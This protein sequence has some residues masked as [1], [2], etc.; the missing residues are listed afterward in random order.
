MSASATTRARSDRRPACVAVPAPAAEPQPVVAGADEAPVARLSGLR[1][2]VPLGAAALMLA[3]LVLLAPAVADLPGAARRLGH[4]D[5]IWL[6]G[7]FALEIASFAGYV[8]LFRAIF[9]DVGSR[10]DLRASAQITLAGTAA[11]RLLA[12]AGAGGVALTAWALRRAGMDRGVVAR[13]MVTFIVVLYGIYMAALVVGGLGLALGLL[14]GSAPVGITIVP[15]AFGAAVIATALS[16]QLVKPG[17]GRV[18]RVLAPVGDGVRDAVGLLRR[19]DPALAGA[20]VWWGADIAVLGACFAAFGHEPPV[21]VL[22]VSYFTGMLANTLPLP[23]GVGGVDGGMVGAFALFGVDPALAIVAV[24]AYRGF[25]F[26]LPI[27]PGALAFVGL[28]RR[29][30]AWSAQDAVEPAPTPP[31]A[32]AVVD[33]GQ[34]LARAA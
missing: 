24:L 14:S 5:P 16:A 21:A 34:Q 17:P 25:S 23:G 29:V 30:A 26:W 1:I 18:A 8:L 11:T 13:R 2:L 19:A 15:A 3:S 32:L 9:V 6:I 22:V 10:I 4:G 7:A 27:A 28:R 12:S 31:V 20:L 33:G